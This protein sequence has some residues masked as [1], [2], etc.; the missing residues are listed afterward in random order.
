VLLKNVFLRA[1]VHNFSLFDGKMTE[2]VS[3]N[4]ES[5]SMIAK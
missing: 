2:K 3:K 5:E 4:V 1:K